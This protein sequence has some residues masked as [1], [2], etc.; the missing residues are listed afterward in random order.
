MRHITAAI[1]V[2]AVGSWLVFFFG[3]LWILAGSGVLPWTVLALP[4]VI[5]ALVGAGLILK[6]LN[7]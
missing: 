7:R 4:A 5:V 6:S 3:V 1:A 2:I